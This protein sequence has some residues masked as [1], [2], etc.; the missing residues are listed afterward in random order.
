MP[1]TY[2][3]QSIWLIIQIF[4]A[5][6]NVLSLFPLNAEDRFSPDLHCIHN[7]IL[8]DPGC[9]KQDKA[10]ITETYAGV[11]NVF[12]HWVNKAYVR[13]CARKYIPL[14][15][16]KRTIF[17][18]LK[19]FYFRLFKTREGNLKSV[20][21]KSQ[22]LIFPSSTWVTDEDKLPGGM[23]RVMTWMTILNLTHYE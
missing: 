21:G 5:F 1:F 4:L 13:S 15:E 3:W 23:E 20:S 17:V 19:A 7:L 10:I 2:F 18:L 8:N 9:G 6:Q 16:N 12:L 14:D 22:V 11:F